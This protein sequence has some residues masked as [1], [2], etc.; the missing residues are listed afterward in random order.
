MT[1]INMIVFWDVASCSLVEIDRRF[2]G[3]YC[4]HHQDDYDDD[5][6]SRYLWNVSI[7]TRLHGTTS[8]KILIFMIAAVRA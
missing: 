8:Q 1:A 6:G 3:A 4:L 5:G 2:R 7:S